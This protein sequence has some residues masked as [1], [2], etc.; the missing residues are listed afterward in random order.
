VCLSLPAKSAEYFS[1]AD[2]YSTAE[3][4]NRPLIVALGATYCQPCHEMQRLY[5]P[6]IAQRGCYIHIDVDRDPRFAQQFPATP[7]VPAILYYERRGGRWLAPRIIVGLPSIRL[8]LG[9][10]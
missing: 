1:Y 9:V 3:Q 4:T 10:K 8:W 5:A 7:M 6:Y 2:A